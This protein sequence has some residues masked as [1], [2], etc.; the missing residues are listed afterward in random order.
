M[1]SSLAL[2]VGHPLVIAAVC[3]AIPPCR[4]VELP[5]PFVSVTL[6]VGQP[7]IAAA[8]DKSCGEPLRSISRSEPSS[9]RTFFS[10]SASRGVGQLAGHTT[11]PSSEFSGTFTSGFEPSFQSRDVGVGQG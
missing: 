10:P 3:S 7:A 1:W 6:G 11:R 8:I 5:A 4:L 2:G 9:V